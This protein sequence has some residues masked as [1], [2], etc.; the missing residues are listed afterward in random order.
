VQ[1]VEQAPLQFDPLGV[2][3]V[4][5]FPLVTDE[6]PMRKV[7]ERH[8]E[9]MDAVRAGDLREDS[10]IYCAIEGILCL[11]PQRWAWISRYR[12][13]ELSCS[14]FGHICPVFLS[15]E[16]FTETREDRRVGRTVPR[17]VMLKVVRRDGQVCSICRKNVPDDEIEFDHVIPH[18]RGGPTTPENLRILCR[19]CNRKKRDSLKGLLAQDLF[20]GGG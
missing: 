8:A 19:P 3:L 14:V 5:Y 15:A 2:D 12:T 10:Q 4:R 7:R 16:P 6:L 20:S 11:E 1:L 9:L 17:D 18:S 13:E